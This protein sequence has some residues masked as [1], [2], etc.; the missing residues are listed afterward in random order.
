M[1]EKTK[2][3]LIICINPNLVLQRNDLFT[4]GVVY[5][6]IGLAYF[7]SALKTKGYPCKVVDAF[8]E[9]PNQYWEE[10]DFIFR[11]LL[12]LEIIENIQNKSC[13][14][15]QKIIFVYAINLTYHQSTINIITQI[16]ESFPNIP[17]AVL[18]NTQ[19]VTAYSLKD[20][21]NEFYDAGAN[22]VVIG[23]PEQQG[24][25]LIEHILGQPGNDDLQNI[26]AI[27]FKSKKHSAKNTTL[28][29]I[30]DLDSLPFPAWDLFPLHNYW[31]LKYAHGPLSA[32]RY[33]PMQTSRG[34]PYACRFCVIPKTNDL[35]WR[36][37]SA[38]HVVNEMEHWIKKLGVKEFHLE[39]VDPTVNDKR[40]Q[41][42]CNE[43]I[44]RKLK[45]R[46]KICSGTKVETIKSEKTIELMAKAGCCYISISP[47]SGSER[48]M[49]KLNKPFNYD[50]AVKLI[51]KMNDVGIYS[52]ACFVLGFPGEEDEDREL[53]RKM[54]HDLTRVGVSEIAQFIITPVPG[55]DIYS[56]F[57]GYSDFSQLNFSPTWRKDYVI[58]NRFRMKLYGEFLWWKL[59]YYPFSILRQ[60]FNFLSRKFN[61]KME[62][63]PYRALHIKLMLK[64]FI[65]K[66]ALNHINYK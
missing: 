55:S 21:Q 9:N 38:T 34:C 42:I 16:R 12:P 15:P 20:I 11:G 54:V 10:R 53:T 59:R 6:P 43:I 1:R 44:K 7:A 18:E 4:T 30:N 32:K 29:K 65:G 58:L 27:G 19:A 41:E 22:Y 57:S 51:K 25:A 13:D 2:K 56:E 45:I 8:G 46:W 40:T 24:I 49:K 31:K 52:Q 5:M 39:D 66:N 63:T 50:H 37:R 64:G 62:M 48:I 14:T 28:K 35:K 61:T 3:P 33:L 60:S 17:I 47:E 36:A 23:E 26:D